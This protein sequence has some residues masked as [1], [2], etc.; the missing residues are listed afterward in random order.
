MIEPM[1]DIKKRLEAVMLERGFE[2]VS[3]RAYEDTNSLRVLFR[4]GPVDYS[5][6]DAKVPYYD[7]H[8]PMAERLCVMI[9]E[10][11]RTFDNP[12]Q[13]RW[14]QIRCV[15]EGEGKHSAY[16]LRYPIGLGLFEK[17]SAMFKCE[18]CGGDMAALPDAP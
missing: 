3:A 15:N 4:H 1:T 2:F 17:M 6:V 16:N 12:C 11:I 10:K 7:G 8:L 18:H 13:E 9:E 5:S 14:M